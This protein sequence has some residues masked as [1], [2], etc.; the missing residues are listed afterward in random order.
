MTRFAKLNGQQLSVHMAPSDALLARVCRELTRSLPTAISMAKVRCLLQSHKPSAVRRISLGSN[1]TVKVDE[2]ESALLRNVFDYYHAFRVLGNACAIAGSNDDPGHVDPAKSVKTCPFQVQLD[3]AD[4]ALRMAMMWEAPLSWVRERDESTRG[5][6]V[7]LMRHG[8]SQGKVLSRAMSEQEVQWS[9]TPPPVPLA[10]R[11]VPQLRSLLPSSPHPRSSEP[12][13]C[14]RAVRSV[15][16]DMVR[17]G[18]TTP[19]APKSTDVMSWS[20]TRSA[21]P[22]IKP[23]CSPHTISAEVEAAWLWKGA[24]SQVRPVILLPPSL[25]PLRMRVVP[26]ASIVLPSIC[27]ANVGPRLS[28]CCRRRAVKGSRVVQGSPAPEVPLPSPK[29]PSKRA[30]RLHAEWQDPDSRREV[31]L[32]SH[33][34]AWRQVCAWAPR[35][36]FAAQPDWAYYKPWL[37]GKSLK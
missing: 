14:I 9:V 13:I 37:R 8:W 20:M 4:F 34:T 23:G 36:V 19:I 35:S 7:E 15:R 30:V 11:P 31:E 5:R 26:K 2:Q 28:G 18:V 17:E 22:R 32:Q 10:K 25:A 24:V 21:D 6:M 1:V 16:D 12:E 3:Y 27:R 29:I 33:S